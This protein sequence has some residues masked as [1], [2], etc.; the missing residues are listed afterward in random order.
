M[1]DNHPDYTLF[2]VSINPYRVDVH[3]V[4][5]I[6]SKAGKSWNKLLEQMWKQA[7]VS[8]NA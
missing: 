2:K 3:A 4:V 6:K 7:D 1:E 8:K 5:E